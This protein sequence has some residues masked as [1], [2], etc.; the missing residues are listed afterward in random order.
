MKKVENSAYWYDPSLDLLEGQKEI[1]RKPRAY[2]SLHSSEYVTIKTNET[3]SRLPT[4]EVRAT[5]KE[6]EGRAR[7]VKSA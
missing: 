1:R 4:Q 7:E 5:A 6:K 2:K 3:A